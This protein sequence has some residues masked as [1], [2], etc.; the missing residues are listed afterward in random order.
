MFQLPKATIVDRFIPKNSFD[1]FINSKQKNAISES[2]KR[3]NW[4]N[5]LS[6]DTINLSGSTIQEIQIFSIELKAKNK[7]KDI[8]NIIDK[9]IPYHIIFIISFEDDIYI[10][11]SAKHSHVNN[12]NQSVIDYT[13]DTEWSNKNDFNLKFELKNS[14]DWIFK[15]FCEAITNSNQNVK[16]I[17]EFVDSKKENDALN[18]EIEKLKA[19]IKNCKQFNKKVELNLKLKQLLDRIQ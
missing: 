17:Q 19:Q 15:N 3:I 7:I 16:S 8:L 14:L 10:S 11:T 4:E 1:Q 6:L 5:R 12:E 9:A 2:I 18:R 13:F